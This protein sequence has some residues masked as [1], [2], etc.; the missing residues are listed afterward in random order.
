MSRAAI[1]NS[2]PYKGG[3]RSLFCLQSRIMIRG[4]CVQQIAFTAHKNQLII[5]IFFTKLSSTKNLPGYS[6]LSLKSFVKIEW[7]YQ[8]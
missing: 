8:F 2:P 5:T 1:K 7:I 3:D 4:G 6:W